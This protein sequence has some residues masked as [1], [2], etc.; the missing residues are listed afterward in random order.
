MIMKIS[1]WIEKKKLSR[2]E[3]A[4]KFG[5]SEG[6]LSRLITGSRTPSSAQAV[7]IASVTDNK[8]TLAD[9]FGEIA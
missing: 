6:Q 9:F 4:K 2:S 7:K 5:I 8:V 1:D 3:A